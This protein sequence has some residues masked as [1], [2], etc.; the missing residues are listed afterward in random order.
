[1]S[2]NA[3]GQPRDE[4]L[5]RPTAGA[6]LSLCLPHLAAGSRCS[7][8]IE[9]GLEEWCWGGTR[10][11]AAGSDYY[12]PEDDWRFAFAVLAALDAT[13][14][15]AAVGDDWDSAFARASLRVMQRSLVSPP[16]PHR[17]GVCFSQLLCTQIF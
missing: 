3:F 7:H 5:P 11:Q 6:G 12:S 9:D 10:S 8:S 2:S 15:D 13:Q 17:V 4:L 14:A 16:S 1:V